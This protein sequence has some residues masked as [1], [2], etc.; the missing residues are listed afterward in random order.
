MVSQNMTLSGFRRWR[1]SE[2]FA[3]YRK[4]RGY[5]TVDAVVRRTERVI[6]ARATKSDRE[7]VR[8]YLARATEGLSGPRK[9][10]SGPTKISA[11]TAALRNWGYDPTGYYRK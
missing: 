7:K 2:A 11:K 4:D 6:R 9:Y 3:E 1:D 10:G 8:S 5:Q